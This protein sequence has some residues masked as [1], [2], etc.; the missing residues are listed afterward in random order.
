MKNN[1]SWHI[2]Y[3]LAITVL[4]VLV[5]LLLSKRNDKADVIEK[6]TTDTVVVTKVDTIRTK[7]KIITQRIVDT[8]YLLIEST[9]SNES[10]IELP[11][12]QK[13]YAQDSIYDI[14]ISGVNPKLDSANVYPRTEYT[15]I[16]KEITKEIYPKRYEIYLQGG[17]SVSNGTLVQRIGISLKSKKDW[18]IS[19]EIALYDKNMFYGLTIGKKIK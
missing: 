9:D 6:H 14:W 4:A 1:H 12:E 7:P 8:L 5:G 13:H 3:L 19:P 10:I 16:T 2:I 11:I 15:T 18:L 17:F